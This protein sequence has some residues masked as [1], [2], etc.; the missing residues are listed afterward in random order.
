[1]LL[2]FSVANCYSYASTQKL[3]MIAAAGTEHEEHNVAS[4]EL[5][6]QQAYRVLKSAIIYGANASGKSNLLKA[7]KL[8]QT[9]VLASANAQLDDPLGITPFK[10]NEDLSHSPSEFEVDFIAEGV[11]YQYG[12]SADNSQIYD[13][14]LYAYPKRQAQLWFMR[15]WDERKQQHDWKYGANFK[16][17]KA[18]WQRSTRKNALFLSTAIQ[19]N[20]KQLQPVFYWFKNVLQFI[21]IT[22][23]SPFY[24][25]EYIHK[26]PNN[27]PQVLRFIR[28][29]DLDIH[30]IIIDEADFEESLASN[31]PA[32]LKKLILLN[33]TKEEK[34]FTIHT[35]RQTAQGKFV[36]FDFSE[37]SA[38]TQKL[39][40]LLAP[41]MIALKEGLVLLVDELDN[42]L[43]TQLVELLIKQFHNPQTNAKNAQLIFTS[44]NTNH[45]N[46]RIFR[47]DQIWFC[48][49]DYAHGTELY[50]LTDFTVRKERENIEQAYLSGRYGGVP[51]ITESQ[52]W[53]ESDEFKESSEAH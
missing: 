5:A 50:P 25:A 32:E 26:N 45:L 12:F 23:I 24:T 46:Q 13:E 40:Q 7:L 39:F 1:M 18:I 17:T 51:F 3:S 6:S 29:A 33:Q 47:R 27:K 14:W 10:L 38:G 49:R 4:I 8:M 43:H 41:W 52:L 53:D 2:E 28:R 9:L 30:D 36:P 31:I 37:E 16:G 35:I 42:S 22:A 34:A 20:N 11:R 15:V 21:G 44:Q 48:E 19:L